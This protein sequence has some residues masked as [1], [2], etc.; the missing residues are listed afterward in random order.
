MRIDGAG[1]VRLKKRGAL[2]LGMYWRDWMVDAAGSIDSTPPN[3]RREDKRAVS[4]PRQGALSKIA[5]LR[6][7]AQAFYNA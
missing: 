2:T 3:L 6:F 1:T 7:A 5:L 4:N